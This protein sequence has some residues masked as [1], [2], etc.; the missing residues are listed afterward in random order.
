M[1]KRI[2]ILGSLLAIIILT[3]AS[4]NTVIG[5]QSNI[6]STSRAS[7]LFSVRSMN[8]IAE[9]NLPLSY[10]YVGKG[11]GNSVYIPTLDTKKIM[12]I[13]RIKRMDDSEYN[14]LII[15]LI[16]HIN[17][18]RRFINKDI[19]KKVDTLHKIIKKPDIEKNIHLADRD[20]YQY[21]ETIGNWDLFC[22][23]FKIA[24]LIFDFF[25]TMFLFL[26]MI[27]GNIFGKPTEQ[28]TFGCDTCHKFCTI[29]STD[30]DCCT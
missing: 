30:P 3:F 19:N 23:Y 16:N 27:V 5:F 21:E 7:P 12:F 8:V 4:F 6:V 24:D 20:L 13:D 9:S 14:R 11:K 2:L 17:K 15:L 1:D 26:I 29:Q 25:I 22:F 10:S 18:D 28:N